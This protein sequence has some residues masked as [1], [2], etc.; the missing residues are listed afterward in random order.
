[1]NWRCLEHVVIFFSFLFFLI[2][3][4]SVQ[5]WWNEHFRPQRDF[6]WWKVGRKWSE[7]E[8]RASCTLL[9]SYSHT[10]VYFLALF[11]RSIDI[12]QKRVKSTKGQEKGMS[13]LFQLTMMSTSSAAC[14]PRGCENVLLFCLR[15]TSTFGK[16]TFL[17]AKGRSKFSPPHVFTDSIFSFLPLMLH[18]LNS[19]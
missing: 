3:V 19:S 13:D 6:S 9:P 12:F 16:R 18:T 4:F 10:L 17:S 1:V 8:E 2:L 5:G 15:A 14:R 11:S 7:T